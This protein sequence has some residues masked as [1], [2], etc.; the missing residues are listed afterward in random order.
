MCEKYCRRGFQL[1]SSIAQY[2]LTR[3]PKCTN[4]SGKMFNDGIAGHLY[5]L[6]AYLAL[7]SFL[8]FFF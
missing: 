3:I 6:F 4:M 2:Y 5:Q 8:F 7:L 1:Q